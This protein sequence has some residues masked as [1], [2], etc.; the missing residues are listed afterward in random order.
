MSY[1]D[2]R[3]DESC[4]TAAMHAETVTC[5][6]EA[7]FDSPRPCFSVFP[8]PWKRVQ[9][10]EI[11]LQAADVFGP[12][13]LHKRNKHHLCASMVVPEWNRT[14]VR[15][16]C[17]CVRRHLLQLKLSVLWHRQSIQ[18]VIGRHHKGH[19]AK[20]PVFNMLLK[21]TAAAEAT[22]LRGTGHPRHGVK[23]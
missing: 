14:E 8:Q 11:H 10:R 1:V 15:V 7:Q 17:N 16:C 20:Q 19:P 3:V 22:G 21:H 6:L 23:S 5:K 4:S 13:L 2:G 18:R 9:Q 12:L